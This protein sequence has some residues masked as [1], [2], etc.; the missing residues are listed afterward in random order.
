MSTIKSSSEHLTLN[1]D[2]SGKEV[3]IQRDGTQVMATTASGIDVTGS[4]TADGLTV[5]PTTSAEISGSISGNY[6]LKLDN[7]HATSGNGLR[8]ETPSV[9]SNEYGL[10]VK[11]NNG[12][13]TNF[14]VSNNGNVGIGTSSPLGKIH[15]KEG[16]SGVTSISSNFDQLV[17]E[18]DLH[19]GMHILSGASQDGAIYFGSTNG[20][21]QGQLKYFHASDSFSIY[22]NDTER[23][24]IDSAGRVTMPYQPAFGAR[25]TSQMNNLS[26]GYNT[27]TFDS[28]IFDQN[29]DFNTGTY[30][31]TA[32]VTGKYMLSAS[33]ASL[34]LPL[35]VQ[36]FFLQISTSNRSYTHST[37]TDQFDA[38]ADASHVTSYTMSTLADM[39][40]GDTAY[41]RAYH[42]T[43]TIQTDIAD[44]YS[45]FNGYL[46]C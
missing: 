40:A 15:S 35:N 2:G 25:I 16:T 39:D 24:H 44:N 37:S 31:F 6:I 14:V 28:E 19:S 8:I 9:A 20:S 18:D 30:K 43:G 22:T 23:M 12:S 42:Y 21:S 32:P 13:N 46:V 38:A 11:S 4:V 34:N 41:V 36:W 45:F 27:V 17:L 33:I 7:T 5:N 1:A 29:S 26:A 10:V 3:K